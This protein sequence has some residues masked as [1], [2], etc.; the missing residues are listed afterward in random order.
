MYD[1]VKLISQQY[2]KKNVNNLKM[3]FILLPS[4]LSTC[5]FKYLQSSTKNGVAAILKIYDIVL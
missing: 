5:T 4:D 2:V 1:M 3:N